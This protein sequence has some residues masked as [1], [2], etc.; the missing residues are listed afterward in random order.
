LMLYSSFSARG[1]GARSSP[2]ASNVN[3][4]QPLHHRLLVL[5]GCHGSRKEK[6]N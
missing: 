5:L 6:K 3:T 1:A 4:P 2:L